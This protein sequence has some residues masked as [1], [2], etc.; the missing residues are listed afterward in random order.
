MRRRVLLSVIAI[1]TAAGPVAAQTSTPSD[2]DTSLIRVGPF[3]ISPSL[4]LRDVGRDE[5]VFNERDNPRSDSTF[6]VVPRAEVVFKPRGMR[7]AYSAA[8]EYVYYQKYASERSTNVSSAVRA[9]FLLS[10]FQPYVLAS[11]INTRQR[12][13]QEVDERARHRERVYGGGL[14]IKAGTRLSFG[15]SAR[16]TRLRFDEDATFRGES[17]ARSFDSDID[18]LEGSTGVQLTPFTLVSLVVSRERQR[19]ALAPERDSDSTRITPTFAF[20]PEAVLNGALAIGYRKFTPRSPTLPAYS[21]F[22]ATATLGTTVWNRH[23]IESVLGR[24]IRYSYERE[25]PYYLA[26]GATVTITTRVVGPFDVRATGARHLLAYRG[27]TT[28]AETRPGDDTVTEYGGGFGYR[29]R[30]RFRLGINAG[31]AHRDSQL[32]GDREY[33]NRR[34]FAS[35]TW[36]KQL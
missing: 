1:V 21:G 12:L 13:N 16:T 19:F 5:N 15:A 24:D 26:T 36:G 28:A 18:A 11:G 32:S 35:M 6:T 29:V 14:T 10:W 8:T 33:R 30:E 7:V 27:R 20:S 23:R 25:T 9:D 34:I 3:A 4:L 31:W 22:V 17:L 2:P